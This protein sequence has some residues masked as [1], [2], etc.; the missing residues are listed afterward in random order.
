MG[1]KLSCSPGGE[2][3]ETPAH[4]ILQDQRAQLEAPERQKEKLRRRF[5]QDILSGGNEITTPVSDSVRSP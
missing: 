4:C 1:A 3:K 2:R 5:K